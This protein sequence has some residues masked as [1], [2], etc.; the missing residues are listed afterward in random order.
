MLLKI[1]VWNK[2]KTILLSKI[3]LAHLFCTNTNP[4]TKETFFGDF[5]DIHL[6]SLDTLGLDSSEFSL[7]N[8]RQNEF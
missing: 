6:G 5:V 3:T 2:K 8:L 1:L 4:N 7:F